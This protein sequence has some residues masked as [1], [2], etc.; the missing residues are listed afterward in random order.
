MNDP[1]LVL[2][3]YL[4]LYNENTEVS[5]SHVDT[6]NREYARSILASPYQFWENCYDVGHSKW[7]KT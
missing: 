1:P 7:N 3:T 6:A 4:G 5:K 2:I